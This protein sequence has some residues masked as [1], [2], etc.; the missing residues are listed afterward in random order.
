MTT[1][2]RIGL[3]LILVLTVAP[4]IVLGVTEKKTGKEYPDQITVTSGDQDIVLDATGVG[5]R[6]KTFLKV[7]VYTIVSYVLPGSDLGQ[8][9]QGLALCKLQQPKRLQMDLRRGFSRDKLINA[10]VEVIEKNYKD[11]SAFADDMKTFEGYFTRDAQDGDVI[12]FNYCP[13]K[14]LTTILNGEE[15]G[16]ITNPAF[17]EALWS[18]WFGQKPANK[19][20]KRDL[21]AELGSD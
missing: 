5:L 16:L 21:L 4:A 6:E 19:G 17:A 3:L 10:F 9:D 15:K 13:T 11:Q 1:T 20:L 7:D 14:G 8:G 18:V 2:Q 12:I